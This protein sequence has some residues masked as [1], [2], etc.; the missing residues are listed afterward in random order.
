MEKVRSL[1]ETGMGYTVVR[2]T[3]HDG[4]EFGQAII[5]SGWLT[6]VRG[7]AD[8]PF[9]E[10]DIASISASHLKWNWAEKP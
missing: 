10:P 1:P 2:I 5:D 8:V 3:L 7:F 6:R 4:R 9:A